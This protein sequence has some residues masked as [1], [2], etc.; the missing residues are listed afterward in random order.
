MTLPAIVTADVGRLCL[1]K[2][3]QTYT[4]VGSTGA[5]ALL[6]AW[7]YDEATNDYG[8]EVTPTNIQI[9]HFGET[10][11]LGKIATA[12]SGPTKATVTIA[13]YY[14]GGSRIDPT[15]AYTAVEQNRCWYRVDTGFDT[16][17]P[18]G[19]LRNYE[20]YDFGL[21]RGRL[22]VTPSGHFV[23]TVPT[24]ITKLL[25]PEKLL[26]KQ[27]DN[28]KRHYRE[29]VLTIQGGS[30]AGACDINIYTPITYYFYITE[31]ILG[32]NGQCGSH[33]S[34]TIKTTF[35]KGSITLGQYA[36]GANLTTVAPVQEYFT[37]VATPT[38]AVIGSYNNSLNYRNIDTSGCSAHNY[39]ETTSAFS[40]PY[41]GWSGTTF[42]MRG[43]QGSFPT[44]SL[45]AG[46]QPSP[47]N[48]SPFKFFYTVDGNDNIASFVINY[49]G[50]GTILDAATGK[51]G[52]I[53]D[54]DWI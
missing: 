23:L 35:F 45:S 26:F 22:F 8:E 31:K 33:Q 41:C 47:V 37:S 16:T 7:V 38:E 52:V 28:A 46:V 24:A 13:A 3:V 29:E 17:T 44:P 42:T 53:P 9:Q 4:L 51:F 1:L 5:T 15:T 39:C 6:R 12:S 43:V 34:Y 36:A 18:L 30:W 32:S 48:T 21:P 2:V 25:K 54:G 19:L 20:L 49:T 50:T 10:L 11:Y 27:Y 14:K 40:S